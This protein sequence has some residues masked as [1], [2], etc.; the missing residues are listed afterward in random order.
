[1]SCVSMLKLNA[2][3]FFLFSFLVLAIIRFAWS[4]PAPVL[5]QGLIRLDQQGV[6]N[7]E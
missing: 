6:Y 3:I 5:A 7:N 2:P 1:M 4:F